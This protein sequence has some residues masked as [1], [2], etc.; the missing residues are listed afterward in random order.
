MF[1]LGSWG[2]FLIIAIAALVL[3]G[4]KEMPGLLRTL[5]RWI[6][7]AK[8]AFHSFRKTYDI[9]LQEGEIEEYIKE[10][11]QSVVREEDSEKTESLGAK[12]SARKSERE[13][14]NLSDTP[15]KEE[16]SDV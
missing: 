15:Q 16:N 11:N 7:K 6:Y 14:K 10:T 4:P 3:I 9:Y 1:D 12:K 2:E 8:K 5:G 13:E